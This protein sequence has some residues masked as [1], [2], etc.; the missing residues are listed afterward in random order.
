M[1]ESQ[2]ADAAVFVGQSFDFVVSGFVR[3]RVDFGFV[4][5]KIGCSTLT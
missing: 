5:Y 3:L 4:S 1:H 2:A